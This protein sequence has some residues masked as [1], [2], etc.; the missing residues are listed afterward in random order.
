MATDPILKLDNQLCFALYAASNAMIRRYREPLNA[1]GLTYPQYLTMLV[2]WESAPLSVKE[3]GERLYLDSG[4]LTPMLKRMQAAGLITRQRDATD[5]RQVNIDL[6]DQGR[7]LRRKAAAMAEAL[8]CALPM[9]L[10]DIARL[11]EELKQFG[12]ALHEAEAAPAE[13]T[14]PRRSSSA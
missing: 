12:A 4:T 9:K 14:S 2:L 5:E 3:I 11:R 7:A 1:F 10:R 8:A 13:I 6:T